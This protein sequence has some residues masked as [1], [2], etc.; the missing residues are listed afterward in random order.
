[1]KYLNLG[2]GGNRMKDPT[3]INI[4]NLFELFPDR[5]RPERIQL[6]MEEN[7]LN[8]DMKLP[9]PFEINSIDGISMCH[10]IE[11]FDCQDSV[12]VLSDCNRVL[13]PGGVLRVGIPDASFFFS[14]RMVLDEVNWGEPYPL[15]IN[16]M[17]YAL[18]FHDH[19]QILNMD[20]LGCILFVS[21]FSKTQQSA[22]G[23]SSL[24]FLAL[25]DTRPIFS[26]FMEGIKE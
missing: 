25:A 18:F 11:H 2:C 8:H 15:G 13:K 20:T 10:V 9:L 19:K 26:A 24:P 3:W 21:G 6:E 16:F 1:M 12:R 17:E 23:Y 22:F 14:K 7:Y 5:D 4:D